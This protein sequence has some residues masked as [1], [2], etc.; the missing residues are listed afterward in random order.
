MSEYD[1]TD[2]EDDITPEST[3]TQ[4]GNG[5]K[6]DISDMAMAS[7]ANAVVAQLVERFTSQIHRIVTTKIDKAIE[8]AIDEKV[9]SVIG[10]RAE[11]IIRETLDKPRRKTNAWGEPSGPEMTFSEIIP[12]I[13][14]SYLDERVDRDGRR[15]QYQSNDKAPRRFDWLIASLVRAEVDKAAKDA[16]GRV[17]EEARK[18]VQTQVGRFVAEQLIP[19]IDAKPIR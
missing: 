10:E 9:R 5:I 3:A 15:E 17:T 8:A 4:D 1:D 16:A 14:R 2:F 19:A 11:A 6:I 12:E 7:F 13:A 18:I